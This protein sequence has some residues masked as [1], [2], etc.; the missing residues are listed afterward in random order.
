MFEKINANNDTVV[1]ENLN[2]FNEGIREYYESKINAY[3]FSGNKEKNEERR[4]KGNYKISCMPNVKIKGKPIIDFHHVKIYGFPAFKRDFLQF[5]KSVIDPYYRH[6]KVTFNASSDVVIVTGKF[7]TAKYKRYLFVYEMTSNVYTSE[8][9]KI[10]NERGLL[11]V[12]TINNSFYFT[13]ERLIHTYDSRDGG[14]T[15]INNTLHSTLTTII[16]EV[17]LP[18]LAG[19]TSS[20]ILKKL[21]TEDFKFMNG[22]AVKVLDL[23]IKSAIR[24]MTIKSLNDFEISSISFK[25]GR[26]AN[27]N[28]GSINFKNI[29]VQ[30]LLNYVH[31]ELIDSKIRPS[32]ATLLSTTLTDRFIVRYPENE[33]NAEDDDSSAYIS[34]I[35]QKRDKELKLKFKIKNFIIGVTYETNL[36]DTPS[37]AVISF[38]VDF[39]LIDFPEFYRFV[40]SHVS[41]EIIRNI[42]NVVFNKIKKK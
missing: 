1:D 26:E 39:D 27:L 21:Q 18:K 34:F 8:Y 29:K 31:Y 15:K 41:N 4:K 22:Y 5:G 19:L 6:Y 32:N 7:S 20:C 24:Y 33:T 3:N 10:K 25:S 2:N 40:I 9:L 23:L 37:T 28:E 13:D 36:N 12:K 30:G 35:T 17:Y 11:R 42:E 16:K 38:D 14:L